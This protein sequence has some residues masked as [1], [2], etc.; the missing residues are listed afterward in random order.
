MFDGS[1][2]AMLVLQE[3]RYAYVHV[4]QDEVLVFDQRPNELPMMP[5]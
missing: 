4:A 1:D 5:N 2:K 3:D